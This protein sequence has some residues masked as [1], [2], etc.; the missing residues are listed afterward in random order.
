MYADISIK[1]KIQRDLI[2]QTVH[3]FRFMAVE[4]KPSP[5]PG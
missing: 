3:S 1:K 2:Q 5:M 4:K